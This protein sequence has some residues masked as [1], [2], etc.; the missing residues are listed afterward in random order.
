LLY[1]EDS[2]DI[3]ISKSVELI[4]SA[5]RSGDMKHVK[6]LARNEIDF[7]LPTVVRSMLESNEQEQFF[8]EVESAKNKSPDDWV[9]PYTVAIHCLRGISTTRRVAKLDKFIKDTQKAYDK[10]TK[11]ILRMYENLKN[12]PETT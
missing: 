10:E 1:M 3:A 8:S 9:A 6:M 4:Q 5:V 2:I 7:N 11:D 12:R